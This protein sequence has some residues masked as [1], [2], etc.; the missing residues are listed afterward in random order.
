MIDR[1][2]TLQG[3][4]EFDLPIIRRAML[5]YCLTFPKSPKAAD[6]VVEVRTDDPGLVADAEALL[7][8]EKP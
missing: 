7:K 8:D 4:K 3:R 6:Y 5:H 2:L 1:I